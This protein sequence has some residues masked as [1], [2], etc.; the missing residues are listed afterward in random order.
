M[1][2]ISVIVP[3]HNSAYFIRTGLYSIHDQA[4]EDYE[5]IVVCD[6]CD[7]QTEREVRSIGADKIIVTEYGNDGMAR[8]AGLDAAE[9]EWIL[10]MDD[11]DHWL[12]EYA[13]NM[14]AKEIDR[15]GGADFMDI[16]QF[17]FIFKGVGYAGPYM[18]E[19]QISRSSSGILWPN[20]WSKCWRRDFIGNCRFEN[21]KMES[22][23]RFSQEMLRPERGACV[24]TFNHALYYYNYMRPGSQ[25]WKEKYES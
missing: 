1:N 5:L 19:P 20:V 2:K 6:A 12:H 11:D 4:F 13:F 9:G 18:R 21:V 3:A 10:F 22:D 25:T 17:G 7:D 8:N 16:L 14:I 24:A 15:N 23:L